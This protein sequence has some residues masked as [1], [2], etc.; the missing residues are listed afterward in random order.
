MKK[1]QKK[2]KQVNNSNLGHRNFTNV[3]NSNLRKCVALS[4]KEA[5]KIIKEVVAEIEQ[6]GEGVSV[7]DID[8]I[9][10]IYYEKSHSRKY[11]ESDNL[12][13]A[14]RIARDEALVLTKGDKFAIAF[15]LL[16]GTETGLFAKNFVIEAIKSIGLSEEDEKEILSYL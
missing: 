9:N 15:A 10:D 4:K 3:K 5:D 6:D 12:N 8:G 2:S 13:T 7:V 11:G 1:H 16:V 14:L